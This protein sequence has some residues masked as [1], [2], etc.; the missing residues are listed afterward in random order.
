[1][2]WKVCLVSIVS[3]PRS[4][5]LMHALQQAVKRH[6]N[7]LLNVELFES[8]GGGS[9]GDGEESNDGGAFAVEIKVRLLPSSEGGGGVT[10][11][12]KETVTGVRD[13]CRPPQCSSFTRDSTSLSEAC[14]GRT[15]SSSQGYILNNAKQHK[16]ARSHFY[17]LEAEDVRWFLFDKVFLM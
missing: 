13:E 10:S 12:L 8:S 15:R 4:C 2:L 11:R 14:T 7:D 3:Y 5:V 9:G 6:N 1:M 16:Y 17:S